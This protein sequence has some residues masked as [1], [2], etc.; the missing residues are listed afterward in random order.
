[1]SETTF[2]DRLDWSQFI[3]PLVLLGIIIAIVAVDVDFIISILL[4][5]VVVATL[6]AML[7]YWDTGK[8]FSQSS[9]E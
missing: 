1:M 9:P 4:V 3:L 8:F 2:L 7:T 6:Y 5:L